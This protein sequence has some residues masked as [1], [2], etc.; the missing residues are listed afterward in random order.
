MRFETRKTNRKTNYCIEFTSPQKAWLAGGWLDQQSLRDWSC[1][2]GLISTTD[3]EVAY[4]L[5]VHFD[6]DIKVIRRFEQR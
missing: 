5:R 2:G 4:K 6:L 1:G 3:L